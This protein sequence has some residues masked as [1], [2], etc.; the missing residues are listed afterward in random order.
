MARIIHKIEETLGV[1]GHRMI[2]KSTRRV[3]NTTMERSTRRKAIV[4]NTRKE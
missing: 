1:G 2:T 3:R 4:V